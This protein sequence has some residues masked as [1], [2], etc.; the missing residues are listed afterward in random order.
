MK[1]T[2]SVSSYSQDEIASELMNR[3]ILGDMA[4]NGMMPSARLLSEE[5][6]VSRLFIREV[7]A[8]LQR[9][10]LIESV[11]GK[12]VYVLKPHIL[13]VA[14]NFHT[15]ARQST[16]TARD[17]IEARANL[18]EQCARLAAERA[19]VKEIE[20]MEIA[21]ESFEQASGLVPKAQA[22][23]AFHALIARA[24]QNPVLQIMF[25]SITTLA[26]ET[27]L[28]SLS[29]P[30]IYAKGAPLHNKILKAIKARDP[31]KAYEAMAKHLHLAESAYKT[32]LERKLSDIADRIVKEVLH[33][34]LTIEDILDSALKDYQIEFLG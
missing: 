24:T 19:T 12:G 9:Q 10:G 6:G 31:E 11:P 2:T 22:D 14:K 33:S 17:L 25:G 26:F 21:L 5:F 32:D 30:V 23:I 28:R 27:M 8:G 15:T 4:V 18:E 29:D 16:A 1:A 20:L 3:Y 13:S 34:D 7:L